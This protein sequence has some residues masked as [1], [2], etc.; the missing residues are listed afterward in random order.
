M[1]A[2]EWKLK[3]KATEAQDWA[4]T[5]SPVI[6]A[7]EALKFKLETKLKSL[8]V[9][10]QPLCK[11]VTILR[12]SGTNFVPVLRFRSKDYRRFICIM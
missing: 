7:D 6:K 9:A 12:N 2:E 8:W 11:P 3:M 10:N 5:F 1:D 4:I